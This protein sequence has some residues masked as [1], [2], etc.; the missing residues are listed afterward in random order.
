[1]INA[2]QSLEKEA[3]SLRESLLAEAED[4][5]KLSEQLKKTEEEREKLKRELLENYKVREEEDPRKSAIA[6]HHEQMVEILKSNM[7]EQEQNYSQ[8]IFELKEKIETLEEQLDIYKN[9]VSE[10]EE[11]NFKGIVDHSS[12]IS[13]ETYKKEKTELSGKLTEASAKE[14]KTKLENIRLQNLTEELKEK[15]KKLGE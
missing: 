5:K 1:L 6:E 8:Q 11:N 4:N 9:K 14:W 7:M 3:E 2:F 12:C 15:N 10:L 13:I